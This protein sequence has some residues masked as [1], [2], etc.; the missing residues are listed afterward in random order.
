MP[1]AAR[2]VG[3]PLLNRGV[4]ALRQAAD[5]LLRAGEFG[6]DQHLFQ[7]GLGPGH[8]NIVADRA[9]KQQVFLQDH[10]KAAAQMLKVD[11]ADIDPVNLDQAGLRL[12]DALDQPGQGGLARTGA[13]HDSNHLA[14][15]NLK[16]HPVQRRGGRTG[17]G[18]ADRVKPQAP[19]DR[20]PRRARVEPAFGLLVQHT[21]QHPHRQG[22]FLIFVDQADDLHQRTG[23]PTGEHQEGD[24]SAGGQPAFQHQS[25]PIANHADLHQFFKETGGRRGQRRDRPDIPLAAQGSGQTILPRLA[26]RGFKD[27]RFDR[28]HVVEGFD[29]LRLTPGLSLIK[30]IQTAAEQRQQHADHGGDG[31]GK[32]Q[33]NQGQRA[34]QQH[35]D[36]QKQ[37]QK[38]RI[39][40]GLEQT[41]GQEIADLFRLLHMAGHDACGGG[42]KHRQ[43]QGHQMR[44]A[45]RAHDSVDLAARDQHQPLTGVA[46]GRLKRCEQ[47][48]NGHDSRQR[49]P[50][51]MGDDAVDQH[52]K[53]QWQA[54]GDQVAGQDRKRHPGKKTALRTQGRHKPCQAKGLIRRTRLRAGEQD[55]AIPDCQ[56]PGASQG[57]HTL[58]LFA[59]VKRCNRLAR[60]DR[61]HDQPAA[62]APPDHRG[63]GGAQA[64]DL[65]PGAA[66]DQL[67][68]KARRG[69][70][71][72]D[73]SGKI[74]ICQPGQIFGPQSHAVVGGNQKC[75]P[76]R[77]HLT[78]AQRQF[79][80]KFWVR[81]AH[82]GP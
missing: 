12:L 82:A 34:A 5:K 16:T 36:A 29:Q 62:V 4:K 44:K 33:D 49:V 64:C 74:A 15:G 52:L 27:Q 21:R 75:R 3:G 14:G 57:L 47:D 24:Q 72:G 13:A 26:P 1:L 10:T 7:T 40:Q 19:A 42:F 50:R 71:G 76:Q 53:Q 38:R 60:Q 25:C 70:A 73:R 37:G 11:L 81:N 45:A 61:H 32:P 35:Q 65:G 48:E 80:R 56:K 20:M 69:Q 22:R 41:S 78:V 59:R 67:G 6:R 9:A 8:R 39:Q 18:E 46:E 63:I 43:G 68:V 51:L 28:A 31:A 30:R 77:R 23:H 17:I 2:Q 55:P 79:A 54:E 58:G 66:F